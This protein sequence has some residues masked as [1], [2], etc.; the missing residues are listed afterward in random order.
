MNP[1]T[2]DT[3]IRVSV[4]N[5][6]RVMRRTVPG[7]VVLA[8]TLALSP[9]VM[10]GENLKTESRTPFLHRILLRDADGKAI[11]LPPLLDA[12]GKPQEA[13]ANPYS[14]AQTCGKCHEYET[15]SRGWHFNSA[16][17]DIKPGRPGEPWILTDTATRTQI[18]LSY[19]GW[20]GT[21]K[22]E[23]IGMSDFD[24]ITA[25]A[26]HLPGGGVGEPTKGKI[27]VNDARMRRLLVTGAQEIDCLICHDSSGHY[28]HDSRFRALGMENIR[29]A[30]SIAAGLGVMGAAKT[31][32]AA[33]DLWKPSDPVPAGLPLKYER[34]KLDME[35][36]A[37][38]DVARRPLVN[39]CYYCHTSE[40]HSGDARW[41]SDGDVHI[42]AGMSC[43]DCH[44]NSLD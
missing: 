10:A 34:A 22:P 26:R 37:T 28:D 18:P 21:F 36:H 32:K 16:R 44:R 43:T 24:F 35:N 3:E 31:G 13:I 4:P 12:Q 27:D 40:S 7:A 30:P 15:V 38:F 14:P 41:H 33:A 11:S 6:P 42:R 25:F 2:F 39:S 8:L 1:E 20:E 29:W 17:D 5:K 23:E 9:S 19:R